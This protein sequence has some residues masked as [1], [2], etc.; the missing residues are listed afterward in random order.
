MLNGKYYCELT[1]GFTIHRGTLTLREDDGTL[2]G[3][4]FPAGTFWAEAPFRNGLID[5][6]K[7]SFTANWG[8]ACQSFSMDVCGEVD[9]DKVSGTAKAFGKE[10]ALCGTRTE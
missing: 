4:M 9:G 1:E 8:T 6:N 10:Y 2:S 3:K 5:G 7:F